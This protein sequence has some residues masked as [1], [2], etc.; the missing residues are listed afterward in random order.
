V[1]KNPRK[2]PDKE[3]PMVKDNPGGP[4]PSDQVTAISVPGAVPNNGAPRVLSP[5][6]TQ[7]VGQQSVSILSTNLPEP[8]SYAGNHLI[9]LERPEKDFRATPG[10]DWLLQFDGQK[11]YVDCGNPAWLQGG[12]QGVSLSIEAWIRPKSS[13]GYHH[14]VSHGRR[15]KTPVAETWLRIGDGLYEFGGA[16]GDFFGV[17]RE[18]V[19]DPKLLTIKPEDIDSWVHL[20]GV[21]DGTTGTWSLY[22]NGNLLTSTN[23]KTKRGVIDDQGW[24]IGAICIEKAMQRFFEG[25][26]AEVRMW[27][28]PR[29]QE[30][31]SRNM[32]SRVPQSS[33]GQLGALWRLN[34]GSGNLAHDLS[35]HECHATIKQDAPQWIFGEVPTGD[36]SELYR[37]QPPER[38]EAAFKTAQSSGLFDPLVFPRVRGP[39]S[40][41]DR[42]NAIAALKDLTFI[43]FKAFYEAG[44]H[45]VLQ[46][47]FSG[48]TI[49]AF[50]PTPEKVRPQLILIEEYRLSS[51]LGAYGFGRTLKSFSL[52]PGESTKMSIRTASREETIAKQSTS[53]LDSYSQE[54]ASEFESAIEQENSNRATSSADFS[55][56]ASA[57]GSA[58]WGFGSVKAEAGVAG[59][60]NSAREEFGKAVANATSKHA[61]KASA[62]RNVQ[63]ETTSQTTQVD[64]K[65]T[66]IVREVANINVGRTLNFVFRQM[67]QE[68]IT[69]LHLV[70]VRIG[71]TSG[72]DPISEVALY[73]VDGLLEQALVTQT[74]VDE[75]R[76]FILDELQGIQDFSG[77]TQPK[78]IQPLVDGKT[79]HVNRDFTTSYKDPTTGTE[80]SVAGIIISARNIV[81]RTE[82]VVVEAL[83]GLSP[84]LDEYAEKLQLEELRTKRIENDRIERQNQFLQDKQELLVD[85]V[86][87][88]QIDLLRAYAQAADGLTPADTLRRVVGSWSPTPKPASKQATLTASSET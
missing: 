2:Y 44:Y 22:R 87:K 13:I 35:T 36:V 8:T 77:A 19:D 80:R 17:R 40:E 84:A 45:M 70:D 71:F 21:Y 62:N 26:I 43:T 29:T 88:G 72:L 14:V 52:L 24:F 23:S 37:P 18:C 25:N 63:V 47:N 81:M 56:R 38:V 64:E 16:D 68:F 69:L 9:V 51:F 31:I 4:M 76:K 32:Y 67:N 10:K 30:Q 7:P 20:A 65:T 82:D 58:S 3:F 48:V 59:S 74:V 41:T 46:R 60:C 11:T 6:L 42:K 15:L 79:Y 50:V 61:A 78:F 73:E 83:I 27:T 54:S 57:E 12:P 28:V 39:L 33:P 66:D 53:I 86:R 55:Y 5:L 75:V 1:E 49:Y 85:L 34:D